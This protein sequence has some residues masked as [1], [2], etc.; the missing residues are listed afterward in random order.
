MPARWVNP[1]SGLDRIILHNEIF[2]NQLN[3][4]CDEK[5]NKNEECIEQEII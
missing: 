4:K 3:I 2:I 1:L 5:R